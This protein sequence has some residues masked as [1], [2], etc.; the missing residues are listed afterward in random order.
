[1]HNLQVALV[2]NDASLNRAYSRLLRA[3]GYTVDSYL[4]AEDFMAA[5]IVDDT[6]TP[7]CLVLDIDLDGM[8]GLALQR[9][10]RAASNRVP[11]VFITGGDD[12]RAETQA[13]AQGCQGFM[14]KPFGGAQLHAAI[15][16]AIAGAGSG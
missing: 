11:I 5:A 4:S 3:H 9:C 15:A 1:M 6:A 12:G 13:H 7:A 10:L 16:A 8:S 2:E 14:R